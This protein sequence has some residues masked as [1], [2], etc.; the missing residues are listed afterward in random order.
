MY[1]YIMYKLD[2]NMHNEK[3]TPVNFASG[4]SEGFEEQSLCRFH[5]L[6]IFATTFNTLNLNYV[7]KHFE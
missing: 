2:Q 6:H 1:K 3:M 5:D 7:S 4:S